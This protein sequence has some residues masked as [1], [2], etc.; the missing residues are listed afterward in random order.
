MK[1][2][3]ALSVHHVNNH[4]GNATN[5]SA[6]V[7][8]SLGAIGLASDQHVLCGAERFETIQGFFC[9]SLIPADV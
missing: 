7:A 1:I 5:E 8:V 4:A 6:D 9:P 2:R 3:V